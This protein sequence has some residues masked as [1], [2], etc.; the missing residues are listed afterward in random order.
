MRDPLVKLD[1]SRDLKHEYRA[2]AD[3]LPKSVIRLLAAQAT[4]ATNM[5]A[6]L[7]VATRCAELYV[8]P[9]FWHVGMIAQAPA[10][11]ASLARMARAAEPRVICE[12]GLCVVP[13]RRG[14]FRT[15]DHPAHAGA[16]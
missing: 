8:Q 14:A 4:A 12:I 6:L 10:E 15:P 16:R 3:S 11:V 13:P 5:H 1:A 2:Y 9:R 7:A